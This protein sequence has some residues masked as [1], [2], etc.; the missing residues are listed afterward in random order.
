MRVNINISE[1]INKHDL[2]D[3]QKLIDFIKENRFNYE[4][5]TLSK[6]AEIANSNRL[7]TAA[8]YTDKEICDHM[9]SKLPTYESSHKIL[10]ILEPSVGIG[11]FLPSLAFKYKHINSVYIDVIDIDQKSI[12]LLKELLKKFDFPSNIKINFICNDFLAHEFKETYDIVIGNPPY[13]KISD[14]VL[15]KKY[16]KNYQ[17]CKTSNLFAFFIEKSLE[18]GEF[19]SLVIPKSTLYTPEQELTRKI[20]EKCKV[21]NITDF[22]EFGFKGVKIETISI[23]I[24]KKEKLNKNNMVEINSFIK[25]CTYHKKQEYI[26]SKELPCWLL[27]RDSFFDEVLGSLKTNVFNVV[28]DRQITKKHTNSKGGVRVIKS[29]NIGNLSIL[30]IN[31]YD[32]YIDN[33][34]KFKISQFMNKDKIYI[35]PNLTYKP[36]AAILPK[37]SI[38]DGSV[39]ILIP[40]DDIYITENDLKYFSSQEFYEYYRIVKNY[41]SRSL[42]LDKNA[43]F[44]WGIK[45]KS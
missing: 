30:N 23:L 26:F 11:N 21:L 20:I 32:T 42:N 18:I 37:N 9:V 12:L 2:L 10:R 4:F 29:R 45:S 31:G 33:P 1:L 39:G 16:R 24:N 5:F 14:S 15:L 44:F 8:Y 35:I 7:N 17:N 19:V 22:G 40:K 41:G 13:K 28:R 3:N 27:Y 36:R 25:S 34:E 43:I 38:T 6:I